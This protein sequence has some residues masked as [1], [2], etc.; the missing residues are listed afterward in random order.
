MYTRCPECNT[1]FRIARE[2]LEA[3]DGEVRCGHCSGIFNALDALSETLPERGPSAADGADPS[4]PGGDA[5]AD[6]DTPAE[7][8]LLA[9]HVI[10]DA[11][12]DDALLEFSL[13]EDRWGEVFLDHELGE[14]GGDADALQSPLDGAAPDDNQADP[15]DPARAEVEPPLLMQEEDSRAAPDASDG[16]AADS[17]WK[18]E[19]DAV[20]GRLA[21]AAPATDGA[22]RLLWS[23]ACVVL[24]ATLAVQ[25]VHVNRAAWSGLPWLGAI[26]ERVY[27][28]VGVELDAGLRV[29]DYRVVSAA[30]SMEARND[31]LLRIRATLANAARH[32][33]PYPLVR[34]TLK[35]RWG[36]SVGEKLIEPEEYV[37]GDMAP[38]DLL[39]PG[40]PVDADIRVVDPGADAFGFEL[41]ICLRGA[42]G[43]LACAADNATR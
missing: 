10:A 22:S 23:L 8:T 39:E 16:A 20:F 32:A 35:D 17:G 1:V 21:R 31:G 41:D 36:E 13:P 33:Q 42:Q 30:A 37:G 43:K 6:T 2:Q 18:V 34:L 28:R 29:T 4:L 24:V 12:D 25:I 38:G 15:R 14:A 19:A 3:A 40:E 5:S 9:D 26:I 27:D 11:G 7:E